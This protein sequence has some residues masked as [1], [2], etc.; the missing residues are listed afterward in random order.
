MTIANESLPDANNS[1]NVFEREIMHQH[2]ISPTPAMH[3]LDVL[4]NP[5]VIGLILSHGIPRHDKY[6]CHIPNCTGV[7]TFSRLVDLKRHNAFKH[8]RQGARFWCPVDGC[9]RS[10]KSE[11]RAFPRKDKMYDHLERVHAD[12]VGTAEE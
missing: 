6:K 8:N 11:G 2:R 3:D 4:R 5:T 7:K 1:P 12:K 10:L 9:D